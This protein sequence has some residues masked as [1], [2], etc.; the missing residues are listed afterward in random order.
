MSIHNS[1]RSEGSKQPRFVVSWI[2]L[3]AILA[4]AI[5]YSSLPSGGSSVFGLVDITA[6]PSPT[7]IG[8]A[9]DTDIPP[10]FDVTAGQ[11]SSIGAF[12][13]SGSFVYQAQGIWRYQWEHTMDWSEPTCDGC[14][15]NGYR[16]R[17]YTPFGSRYYSLWVDDEEDSNFTWH[18]SNRVIA[19]IGTGRYSSFIRA[20]S[21]DGKLP[22]QQHHRIQHHPYPRNHHTYPHLYPNRHS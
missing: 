14:T 10:D 13:T 21:S 17:L 2:V 22:R 19:D 7:P 11:S 12:S 18:V 15:I 5:A 8:G 3:L 4:A 6:T 1:A 20:Y 9:D 16:F